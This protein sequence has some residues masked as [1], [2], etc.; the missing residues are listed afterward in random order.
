MDRKQRPANYRAWTNRMTK[1][2]TGAVIIG[3]EDDGTHIEITAADDGNQD[4]IIA[5]DGREGA[6]NDY[7]GMQGV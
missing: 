3:Y 2:P 7:E 5:A 4:E 6:S 1:P